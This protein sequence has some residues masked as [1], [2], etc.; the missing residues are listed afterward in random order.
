MKRSPFAMGTLLIFAIIISIAHASAGDFPFTYEQPSPSILFIN[1]THHSAEFNGNTISTRV[2]TPSGL[3][4][5]EAV[6]LQ[7]DNISEEW[8]EPVPSTVWPNCSYYAT[9]H[10]FADWTISYVTDWWTNDLYFDL[11]SNYF[12]SLSD[13]AYRGVPAI[14]LDQSAT[15]GASQACEFHVMFYFFKESG[16]F[17]MGGQTVN[18]TEGSLKYSFVWDCPWNKAFP[19]LQNWYNLRGRRI[20][21][22]Y[23][24]KI[25]AIVENLDM[26]AT[27]LEYPLDE[28][29]AQIYRMIALQPRPDREP[30]GVTRPYAYGCDWLLQ[31]P[32]ERPLPQDLSSKDLSVRQFNFMTPPAV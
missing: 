27:L 30:D 22:N 18:A 12:G 13:G 14:I 4:H 11:P 21:L 2:R 15:Y 26:L 19:S 7:W 10:P 17:V 16:S 5:S 28:G 24:M 3:V 32:T 25:K 9:T 31:G 20:T 8:M 6:S 1:T 29:D 23:T